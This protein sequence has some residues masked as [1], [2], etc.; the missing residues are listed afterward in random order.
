[1]APDDLDGVR[2]FLTACDLTVA[3][4]GAAGVH[5]W[6]VRDADGAIVATTGYERSADGRH[7]LLRSVAV[8]PSR[9][10]SGTGTR[11]ARFAMAAAAADG[12]EVAWLFSRRSGPFWQALGFAPADRA[13]LAG[14]LAGTTQVEL[15]RSSGQLDREVAWTRPIGRQ[16]VVPDGSVGA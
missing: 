4:L 11:L 15:F 1:M 8:G 12:A 3:G 9:R 16:S 6:A 5:L 7:A 13:E 10:G 14:A 2:G